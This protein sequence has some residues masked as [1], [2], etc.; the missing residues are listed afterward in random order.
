[1]RR[2]LITVG[3]LCLMTFT[4]VGLKNQQAISLLLHCHTFT[5]DSTCFI[6]SVNQELHHN[7]DK[8]AATL[9]QIATLRRIGLM[10][11]DFRAYSLTLHH[12]GSMYFMEGVTFAALNQRCPRLVKDGCVHGYVM[13]YFAA[14]GAA[15]T[16][17]L[18]QTSTQYR[19]RVGC[20]HAFGHSY[21]ENTSDSLLSLRDMCKKKITAEGYVPCFSGVLHEYIR[22]GADT[23]DHHE[24]YTK[25]VSLKS[26]DCN[27]FPQASLEY[28]LCYAAIGSFR[29]YDQ[30]S[31]SIQSTKKRCLKAKSIEAQQGCLRG[32]Y[33]RIA[34]AHGY[35]FI[36]N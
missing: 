5:S 9:E 26:I 6:K 21:A 31:E 28:S 19:L 1:M 10:G 23:H 29:Q 3:L 30:Y 35:S 34:I 12:L 27:I 24:Y 32:V 16:Q 15:K 18:C 4:I 20:F 8:S 36:P 22:G 25:A 33:E 2:L 14:N 13:E 7:P 17:T 11:G